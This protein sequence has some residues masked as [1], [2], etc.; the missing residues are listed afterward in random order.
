MNK[1]IKHANLFEQ[2]T[3]IGSELFSY[4]I[5]LHTT[6]CIFLSI[7]SQFETITLKIWEGPVPWCAKCSLQVSVHGSK[8]LLA[9]AL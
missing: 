4:L 3:A 7:F 2:R 6:T 9:S 8:T 1:E 5:C